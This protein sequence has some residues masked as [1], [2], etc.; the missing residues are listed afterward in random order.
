MSYDE[1]DAARDNFYDQI[2]EELYPDHKLQAIEEFT[3]DRLLSFYIQHPTVMLQAIDALQEGKTLLE[4][5]RYSAAVVFFVSAVELLLKATLLKPVVYG[6]VHHE[7]LADIIVQHALGQT[8]FDRYESLLANLFTRLAKMDLSAIYRE[9]ST[10]KLLE[11]SKRLQKLR[12]RII[13]QGAKATETEADTALLVAV[14]TYEKI[15][16]PMLHAIGL[17]VGEKGVISPSLS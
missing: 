13:H 2:S 11:E 5:K 1:D 8:G 17:N 10:E 12:N 9:G 6:L 15:V 3:A 4:L 14:A 7:A 16:E